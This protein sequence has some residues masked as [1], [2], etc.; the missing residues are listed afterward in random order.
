MEITGQNGNVDVSLLNRIQATQFQKHICS[1]GSQV[2][3]LHCISVLGRALNLTL[4]L[5]ERRGKSTGNHRDP[6]LPG[7]VVALNE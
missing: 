2:H 3:H 5:A 1:C 7:Q 6:W 4:T